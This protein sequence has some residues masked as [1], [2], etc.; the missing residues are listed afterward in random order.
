MEVKKIKAK[1]LKNLKNNYKVAIVTLFI[2]IAIS[3][4]FYGTSK[5]IYNEDMYTFFNI[6]IKGLFYM[7]LIDIMVKIAKEKNPEIKDLFSKMNYFWKCSAV[8]IIITAFTILCGILEVI[9]YKSLSIFFTFSTDI[10]I[11]LATTM[12]IIGLLL[13][14][15]I[16]VFYLTLMISFSQVYYILY[17]NENMPVLDIFSKSMDL[18]ENHKLDYIRFIISFIGWAFIGLFTFGILYLWLIPYIMVSEYHFY[19]KLKK[20]EKKA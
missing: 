17:E 15:A 5:L 2:Y 8:T 3:A 20:I 13:C 19:E 6:L 9:A 18:M 1:A 4:V 7:G 16:G 11:L 14:I 10:N 12:I